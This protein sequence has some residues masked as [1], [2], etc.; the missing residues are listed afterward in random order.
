MSSGLPSG[1]TSEAG[2]EKFSVRA[3]AVFFG[4]ASPQ[5]KMS[6]WYRLRDGHGH[7]TRARR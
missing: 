6:L 3:P 4:V 2:V 1:V 7:G 5:S